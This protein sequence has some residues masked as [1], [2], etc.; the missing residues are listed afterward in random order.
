MLFASFLTVVVLSEK[1][2]AQKKNRFNPL[3]IATIERVTGKKGKENNGEYKI[4]IPQNDLNVE[5]DGFKIIPAMPHILFSVFL[6]AIIYPHKY[7]LVIYK[8]IA[9]LI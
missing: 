3:D 2:L 6:F 5:V 8:S 9:I 1:G 7:V 4:T